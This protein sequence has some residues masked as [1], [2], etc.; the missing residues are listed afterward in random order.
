MEG[1]VDYMVRSIA[2]HPD[3]IQLSAHEGDASL[4]LELEVHPED[5]DRLQDNDGELL[6][7]MKQVLVA[8]GGKRKAVL[9]LV[10]AE[11]ASAEE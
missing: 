6:S 3:S 1:L 9:D 2:R 5:R 10:N 4:L 11:S 8:A 7:A